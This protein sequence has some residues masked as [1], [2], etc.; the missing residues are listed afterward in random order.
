MIIF[1]QGLPRSGKSYEAVITILAELKKGRQVFTNIDGINFEKF[2]QLSGIPLNKLKG[3]I[4]EVEIAETQINDFENVYSRVYTI[5]EDT[6]TCS[7]CGKLMSLKKA[8]DY[9]RDKDLID[10]PNEFWGCMSFPICR[11]TKPRAVITKYFVTKFSGSLFQLTKEDIPVI[12]SRVTNNSTVVIDEIQDFFP[13][14]TKPLDKQMTEFVT[15]HGHRGIN[16]LLMGQDHADCHNLFKRRID[17]LIHFT[18]RDA[19]GMSNSYS[20]ESYKLSLR[21][22][23]KL[24]SGGGKYNPKYFGLYMSHVDDSIDAM[25]HQDDRTNVLK[26]AVFTLYIPGFLVLV[27]FAVY[28]LYS[29]FHP[30][31]ANAAI[32]N[33]L[34][35]SESVLVGHVKPGES[36][37]VEKPT[38]SIQQ[39][40]IAQSQLA[41]V[42]PVVK[43]LT[44]SDPSDYFKKVAEKY[45]LQLGGIVEGKDSK[46]DY[47][48][49]AFVDAFDNDHH[50]KERF[51][52]EELE[53]MGWTSTRM[54][55]GVLL[56]HGKDTYI[57]R[58]KPR[59]YFGQVAQNVRNSP[60]ITGQK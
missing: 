42:Q 34:D 39:T 16:L 54:K 3:D 59:D 44:F 1:H 26:S 52:P 13:A 24:R 2:S 31:S 33:K 58:Q 23:V 25:N 41:E 14:V 47:K 9:K 22:L 15:Q 30:T 29:F 8:R 56:S 20:W 5:A 37:H 35:S 4:F 11:G 45:E 28:Y 7:K 32:S 10:L 12:Y 46:G 17:K 21:G 55:Y 60:E 6:P 48:F 36:L 40:Q 43:T 27:C 18:K 38:Q 49:L 50:L 51:S 19:V 53:A 57:V